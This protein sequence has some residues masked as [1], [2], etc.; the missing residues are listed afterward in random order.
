MM[1]MHA[2]ITNASSQMRP[3]EYLAATNLSSMTISQS[4]TTTT[5]ASATAATAAA[6]TPTETATTITPVTSATLDSTPVLTTLVS[7]C[8]FDENNNTSEAN[9]EQLYVNL[10]TFWYCF[11]AFITI[12]GLLVALVS[13]MI[14]IYLFTK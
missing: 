13:N 11:L 9:D 6:L 5:L 14:I 4:A 1:I 7:G 10:S 2:F 12:L 8:P 3:I